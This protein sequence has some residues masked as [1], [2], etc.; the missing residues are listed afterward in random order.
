MLNISLFESQAR[1]ERV[2][3]LRAGKQADFKHVKRIMVAL[4]LCTKLSVIDEVC[5]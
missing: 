3:F 4:S 5:C 2:S 1:L